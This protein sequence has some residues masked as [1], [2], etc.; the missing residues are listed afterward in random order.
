[1]PNSWKTIGIAIIVIAVAA[2]AGVYLYSSAG[3]KGGTQKGENTQVW[4][5]ASDPHLGNF[6]TRPLDSLQVAIQDVEELGIVDHAAILG[7]LVNNSDTYASN[8]V[9]M[10]DGLNLENW[11]YV[12]GNH[13]FD[14]STG[15]NFFPISYKA[16]DVWG[17]R[18]VFISTEGHGLPDRIGVMGDDQLAWLENELETH[19]NQ[20]VFMFSHQPYSNWDV[21]PSLGPII[22]SDANVKIW[23][24]GHMHVWTVNENVPTYNFINI[25]DSSLD[26]SQNY[27]GVF[28]FLQ[29][30]GNTVN[31]TLKFRDH[32]DHEWI[33]VPKVG[34]GNIDSLSFSVQVA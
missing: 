6:P 4:W 25:C 22:Q 2:S 11:Y 21:W 14:Q 12:T 18:F 24:C 1:M 9:Q 16:I 10:M 8:F 17:I 32:R 5:I 7:D 31:V 23:F 15:E 20:P 3:G 13:D 19:E 34:G 33:N 27:N 30:E 29:R 26:W 28:M